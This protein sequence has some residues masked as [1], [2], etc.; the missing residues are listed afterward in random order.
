MRP[1]VTVRATAG[2][3]S[4]RAV[5]ARR[6]AGALAGVRVVGCAVWLCAALLAGCDNAA[7][8][9][10]ARSA[11]ER[12]Q[13]TDT[14]SATQDRS[15]E[16]G[17]AG[18]H[19]TPAHEGDD[20]V[21]FLGTSLTAGY[22][23]DPDLAFPAIV[24]TEI[25][26]AGLPFRVVNAGVSGETSAGGLRRLDWALQDRVAALVLELGANDGLRGL[27]LQQMQ[28]NLAEII[29]QTRERWP[30]A[31]IIIAGMEA[32]PNLGSA[33]TTAFRSVFPDLARE[34]DAILIPFLLQ[35]VAGEPALNLEDR[36]HPNAAGH[37]IIA[38]TVWKTLEPALLLRP[39]G[40]PGH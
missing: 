32:P 23:L 18:T 12:P 27:D 14:A 28:M 16:A 8:G 20:V 17:M 39:A 40:P 15:A 25:D 9:H 11:L 7:P 4:V 38:R 31:H 1:N 5:H 19:T 10:D 3:G 30:D 22:G 13:P 34:Y 21:L 35:D 29:R 36:I 26:R 33:Y 6:T 24:Q 2:S 37:Q